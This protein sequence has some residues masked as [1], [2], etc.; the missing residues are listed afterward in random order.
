MRALWQKLAIATNWPLLAAVLVLS[1]LG[2]ICI[3][4]D[5]RADAIKQLIFL[6]VGLA[7]MAAFQAVNYLRIGRWSWPFYF[8]SLAL[9]AYTVAGTKMN[10]PGVRK[11]NGACA[12]ITFGP[13]GIEPAESMKH[14]FVLVLACYLRLRSNYRTHGGG[15]P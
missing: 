13:V 8:V 12:W 10:V 15:M 7:C 1:V 3:S 4:A 5:A 14:A 2:V 11:V 6:G 9:V